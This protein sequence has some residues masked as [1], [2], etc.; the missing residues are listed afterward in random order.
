MAWYEYGPL[1]RRCERAMKWLFLVAVALPALPALAAERAP[2]PPD[3]ASYIERNRQ[4]AACQ[5]KQSEGLSMEEIVDN[6]IA[7][8]Q[9]KECADLERE[10]RAL[11]DRYKDN[12]EIVDALTLKIG[13]LTAPGRI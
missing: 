13:F 5:P 1:L 10:R 12:P 6:F 11:M 4:T 2:L 8:R 3:V 7:A 9:S